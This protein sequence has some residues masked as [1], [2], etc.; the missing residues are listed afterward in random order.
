[1]PGAQRV[2]LNDTGE[3]LEADP[4]SA[5]DAAVVTWGFLAVLLRFSMLIR[6]DQFAALTAIW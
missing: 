4:C 3:D 5:G 2:C 1:M 6:Y